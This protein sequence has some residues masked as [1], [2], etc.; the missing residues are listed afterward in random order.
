MLKQKDLE[1]ILKT[2]KI[3][4]EKQLKSLTAKAG[5][6]GK[7]LEDFI[8]EQKL[9]TPQLLY[10]SAAN[11]YKIP[12]F[13]LKS[14]SIRQ[15]ILL[16]IPKTAAKTHQTV[17]F[18]GSGNEL[19]VATLDPS[20]L[21][22]FDF[23]AKKTELDLKLHLTTPEGLDDALEQYHKSITAEFEDINVEMAKK[24]AIGVE[25]LKDLAH[26]LP[27]VKIVDT[28][29]DY[30]I[31]EKASDIHI[32]PGEQDVTIRFRVDGILRKVMTLPK[33]THDGIIARLKILST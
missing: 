27:I 18:D 8:V 29:L 31:A 24:G 4:D 28:F 3:L 19:K 23:L 6:A 15:D 13:D 25:S 32:E 16:L 17:A 30:A 33:S 2:N 7:S 1:E 10:E 21:E 5:A 22:F 14:K 26:D 20:D 9:I 11:Y 12:F